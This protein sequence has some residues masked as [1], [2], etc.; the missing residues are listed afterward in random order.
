MKMVLVR[1]PRLVEQADDVE[2]EWQCPAQIIPIVTKYFRRNP[3]PRL[4]PP[5]SRHL[6]PPL[7]RKGLLL[8]RAKVRR[9]ANDVA[10]DDAT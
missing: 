10:G 3:P 6:V 4:H 2:C 9:V 1:Q 7:R 5:L 8:M